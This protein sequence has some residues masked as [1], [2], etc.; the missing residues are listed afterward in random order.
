MT[1]PPAFPRIP[2]LRPNGSGDADDLHLTEA[3]AR[4]WFGPDLIVEEKL[5][6]ANVAVWI[7]EEE[8]LHCAGRGG[9]R[10]MDRAHQFGRLR[11][12]MASSAVALRH[13]LKPH[14]VLYGEW[15]YLQHTV[16]YDRLPDLL[17]VL[18]LWT[19]AGGFTAAGER[20][21][22]CQEVALWAAP[23]VFR[24]AL[25]GAGSL[26]SLS[27]QS[28]VGPGHMEGLILRREG[29]SQLTER[30]KWL[31]PDFARL[32]DAE[33]ARGRP[34]NE[35]ASPTAAEAPCPLPQSE[36]AIEASSRWVR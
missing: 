8:C 1:E 28:T 22:R 4:R 6:G 32:D 25:R 29:Q 35:R 15:L 7:D 33:W 27:R 20:D 2:H 36:K 14:E 10:A 21:R 34:K 23:S 30:V 17:C 26:E 19:P 3:A 13:L 18:D 5:D 31:R 12:W 24:G 9:A 16:R 11:A